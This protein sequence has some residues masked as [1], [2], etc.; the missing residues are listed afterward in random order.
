MKDR[1]RTIKWSKVKE[2]RDD[3]YTWD[4]IS[5]S[6]RVSKATLYRMKVE[7]KD[8]VIDPVKQA[9]GRKAKGKSDKNAN[10]KVTKANTAI[11]TAKKKPNISDEVAKLVRKLKHSGYSRVTIDLDTETAELE[12]RQ[13]TLI[14]VGGR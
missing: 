11:K 2:M 9:N 5:E 8:R 6:L 13:T 1:K 3:G 12:I 7:K 14:N 10:G 4:D